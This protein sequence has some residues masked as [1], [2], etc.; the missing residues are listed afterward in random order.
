MQR[1]MNLGRRKPNEPV[2]EKPEQPSVSTK[3]IELIVGLGN[4][5]GEYSGNRHNVGFWTVNRLGRKIGIEVKKHS[6]LVSTGEGEYGGHRLV[7]AKPRTFMNNSGNAVRELLRRYKLDPSQALIIYDELD[8]PVAR[9]RIRARGGHGGQK[10]IRNVLE[11][12]GSTDV[13]RIRIG[14]GRP[15]VDGKPSWE[16]EHVA[17]WVLS[18]PPPE[19][20]EKLDAAVQKAIDA[21]ICILDE[22]IETA[23][24]RY[25]RD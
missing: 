25:N 19:D 20:R 4:P 14:I 15:V 6:G 16:P 11:S 5:G 3:P 22:G 9:V 8:L 2:E 7:L 12:M 24:N 23:M 1:I 21:I 18:D 13:P 10:G 17:D